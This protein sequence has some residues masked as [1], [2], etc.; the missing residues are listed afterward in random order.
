MA[1]FERGNLW[2]ARSVLVHL[3]PIRYYVATDLHVA[4]SIQALILTRFDNLINIVI[5]NPIC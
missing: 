2:I 5:E 3:N 4:G 1:V